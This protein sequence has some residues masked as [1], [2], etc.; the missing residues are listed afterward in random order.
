MKYFWTENVKCYNSKSQTFV[1]CCCVRTFRDGRNEKTNRA[2]T[3]DPALLRPVPVILA[4]F[5]SWL[6]RFSS[7]S[8]FSSSK[9]SRFPMSAC[10]MLIRLARL[11]MSSSL[12]EQTVLVS[13]ETWRRSVRERS[14]ERARSDLHLRRGQVFICDPKSCLCGA[15][16]RMWND[17]GFRNGW[18]ETADLERLLVQLIVLLTNDFICIWFYHCSNDTVR[19]DIFRRW[20]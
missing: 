7:S 9:S 4:A 18:R 20:R 12:Q 3:P 14:P 13:R 11:C 2:G 5:S 16:R 15:E 17:W 19:K 6:T 8:S 1:F 10:F